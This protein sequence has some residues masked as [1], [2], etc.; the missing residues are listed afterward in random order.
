MK[1]FW[2]GDHTLRTTAF[3]S[4][5]D[6]MSLRLAERDRT[7]RKLFP[8]CEKMEVRQRSPSVMKGKTLKAASLCQESELGLRRSEVEYCFRWIN[9]G[10]VSNLY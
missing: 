7:C 9:V 10:M 8:L 3:K 4:L 1:Y 5:L 2:S 6:E